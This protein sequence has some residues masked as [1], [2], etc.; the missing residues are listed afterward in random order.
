MPFYTFKCDKGHE[1]EMLLKVDERDTPQ[2]C[3][4]CGEKSERTIA[5]PSLQFRG[6]WFKTSGKY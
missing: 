5:A 1:F 4:V 2:H 6:D 3:K